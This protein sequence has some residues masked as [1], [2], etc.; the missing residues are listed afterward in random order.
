MDER[1]IQKSLIEILCATVNET[2]ADTDLIQRTTDDQLASVYR[3]AKRHDLAH[4]V[5]DFVYRNKI[6]IENE[7][8]RTRLQQEALMA[9]YRHER[10]KHAFEQICVLF[11]EAQIAYVPLKG[12]VI[13]SFY[14]REHM[15]TSCDIDILIHEKDL[16]C[17]ISCL[18]KKGYRCEQRNYHDVSLYSPNKTHLEL[19]FNVQENM[20]SLDAV[21]K[22]A[23]KHA[24]LVRGSRYEFN[25]DFF[26]FHM[27]A[28][29]AYH[30]LSGGCGI[31]SLIDLWIM[32]HKMNAHYSCAEHLLK[33]AGIYSFAKEMSS[34]ANKCFSQ[35]ETDAFS[36]LIIK[37]IF[38]G[39]V[40]GTQDNK[41]AVQK[42]RSKSSLTYVLKRLFVP[43]KTMKEQY[44]ALI[45]KPC[46]LPFYWLLRCFK[47]VFKGKTKKIVSEVVCAAN[48]SDDKVSE[49]KI[50][51]DRLGI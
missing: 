33:K 35:K 24:V 7:E 11:D 39:G 19:H 45:G 32:E 14:P 23:W 48:V 22:D 10:M 49:I 5:S 18:V 26:V 28:H 41:V 40:Y 2:E 43:Y 37:Y 34:I 6:E 1:E 38:S 20:D 27:Y 9:V 16:D 29:M 4:V 15:R 51:R 31:R 36:E 25:K 17:A 47:A 21:L 8:L 46:L 44:P 3:L 30:F 12:A 42:T 13:R 50:I